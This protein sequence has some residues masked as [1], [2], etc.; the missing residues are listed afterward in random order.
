[1]KDIGKM[2]NFKAK[3]NYIMN[4]P[5]KILRV[6]IIPISIILAKNGY[7]MKVNLQYYRLG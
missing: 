5:M 2:I 6:L 1:M 4:L 7:I 3:E